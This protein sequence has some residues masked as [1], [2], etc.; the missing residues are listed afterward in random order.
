MAHAKA[1]AERLQRELGTA[2]LLTAAVGDEILALLSLPDTAG[3]S[4]GMQAGERMPLVAPVGAPFLAWSTE[5]AIESWISR[6]LPPRDQKAVKAWRHT[7]EL[8]RKRGYQVMLRA[9]NSQ[10]TGKLMAEM[11][12]G[13]RTPNHKDEVLR[14]VNSFGELPQPEDIDPTALYDILVISA[15]LFDHQGESALNLS[16][17]GFSGPLPGK[18]ISGL[19][20]QL[21]RT[22]LEIMRLDRNGPAKS[23]SDA[24]TLKLGAG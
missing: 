12:S 24:P 13:R 20:D 4:P 9:P 19:A 23:T 6:H 8:T 1:G 7:L 17:F 18:A 10:E 2:V 22:C 16:L 3:R 14:L 21:V 11:A 5:T 15:P